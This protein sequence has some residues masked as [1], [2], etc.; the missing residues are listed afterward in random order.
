MPRPVSL[1]AVAL[2]E[3][4]RQHA[5]AS[6]AGSIPLPLPRPPGSRLP[7]P[8]AS[9]ASIARAAGSARVLVGVRDHRRPRRRGPAS[10]AGSAPRPEVFPTTGV[11]AATVPS[12][13]ALVAALRTDPRV[14]Y[15]E[16]DRELRA[17][18][19]PFDASTRHRHQVH[20]GLRRRARRDALA[21]RGRRLAPYGGGDRHGPRRDPSRVRGPGGA[22]PRHRLR[23][24][25]RDR[26]RR[27]RDLRV[28]ADLRVDGNASAARAW[29]GTPADR[30]NAERT[31]DDGT[32][33]CFSVGDVV[34]GIEFAIRSGADVL[35]MS[36]AGEGL[37]RSQARA[38]EAAFFN[39]VLPVAA[40]GNNAQRPQEPNPLEF[41]A[42]AIGG[43]A[44][45]VA[46]ASRS[47]PRCRTAPSRRSR[48]TTTS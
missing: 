16:R 20:L 38:L 29:L 5:R 32:R 36:L 10:C 26:Q 35:N 6:V 22:H 14:A 25:R 7:R 11:L 48:P 15:I 24:G 12:G 39:D 42:A 34:R 21:R 1:T 18:A 46:S 9:W 2:R 31:C 47:R 43:D 27:T 8:A 30:R 41:P 44:A 4:L 19:D 23:H 17:A 33:G 3:V 40:S 28:G 13:A 37:T 45:G